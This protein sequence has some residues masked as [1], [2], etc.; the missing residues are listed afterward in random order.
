MIRGAG[1]A[2]GALGVGAILWITTS[3]RSAEIEKIVHRIEEAA[4]KKYVSSE[5]YL[6][7]VSRIESS[8]ALLTSSLDRY[9][10][11]HEKDH[12][13]YAKERD[14]WAEERTEVL[15]S[16][17]RLVGAKV[18]ALA[19]QIDNIRSL[20]LQLHSR[21]VGSDIALTNGVPCVE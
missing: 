9:K 14:R 12:E 17:I 16:E 2:L 3:I 8:I 6:A 18:D 10:S 19:K 4:D 20:Q 15:R 5:S 7:T 21:D 1:A 11:D 13:R